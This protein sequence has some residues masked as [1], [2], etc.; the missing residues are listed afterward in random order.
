MIML[1]VVGSY[2]AAA[3]NRP[4]GGPPVGER[5]VQAGVP[6][7]PLA[8][9]RTHTSWFGVPLLPPNTIRLPALSAT[10]LGLEMLRAGPVPVGE[11]CVQLCKAALVL[12]AVTVSAAL[13]LLPT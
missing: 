12:A 3:R 1:L 9:V 6:F 5:C 8:P 4:A 13:P 10:R 7:N 2:T 11:S